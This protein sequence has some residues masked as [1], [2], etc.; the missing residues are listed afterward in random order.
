MNLKKHN[1]LFFIVVS[2]VAIVLFKTTAMDKMTYFAF[3]FGR[4]F[5]YLHGNLALLLYFFIL[6]IFLHKKHFLKAFLYTILTIVISS[7][8]ALFTF[9]IL[10]NILQY[11]DQQRTP[12][13]WQFNYQW[14]SMIFLSLYLIISINWIYKK[15]NR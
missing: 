9:A 3:D 12:L 1:I 5:N 2:V 8:L 14:F 10:M 13:G 6:N 15:M 4:T 7:I 11:V